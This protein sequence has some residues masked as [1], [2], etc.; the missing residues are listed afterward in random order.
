MARRNLRIV[1]LGF[2]GVLVIGSIVGLYAYQTTLPEGMS[3]SGWR[4]EGMTMAEVR[5]GLE[6]KVEAFAATKISLRVDHRGGANLERSIPFEELGFRVNTDQAMATIS[7]ILEGPPWERAM[8]YWRGQPRELTLRIDVDHALMQAALKRSWPE[9]YAGEP[10]PARRVISADDT[11][12]YVPETSVQRISEDALRLQ[13][14]A[15]LPAQTLLHPSRYV[16]TS[17]ALRLNVPV[18]EATPAVTVATLQAQGIERKIASFSTLFGASG[19]GRKHNVT[20]MA[21]VIHDMLLAPGDMFD[22]G[23]AVQQTKQQFGFREAPVILNGRLV[24]G[25]GGGICQVSSTL[26]NAALRAG[27]EIV[28]RRNHSLPIGYA[29]PGLDATFASGHINFKFRNS[30]ERHLLIRTSSAHGKLVVKLF[31]AMQD[32][33]T[34][35]LKTVIL[36]KM[37]PPAKYVRNPTLR[38]GTVQLLHA[39]QAGLVVETFRYKKIDGRIV[40]KE[41]ISRDTYKSQPKLYAS[42]VESGSLQMPKPP[43]NPSDN[44][45]IVEDGVSPDGATE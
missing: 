22:F 4:V 38:P 26:Y 29:P 20:S 15:A 40:N 44:K 10:K 33:V 31:G 39:G 32:N 7:R 24:P 34:Y 23:Q 18:Y 14:I 25:V 28:E 8:Q 37:E 13:L 43:V 12:T 45:P 9:L 30:T 21:A 27:L 19:A 6:Q 16:S 36:K 42:N 5:M 17:D 11:V 2:M 35:T 3:V 1:V 41:L